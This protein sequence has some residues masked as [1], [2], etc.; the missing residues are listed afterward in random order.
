MSHP[1]LFAGV[2]PFNR[3]RRQ[4]LPNGIGP[5][6]GT[7]LVVRRGRRVRR[8]LAIHGQRLDHDANDEG[9][10]GQFRRNG[11]R[12]GG[13]CAAGATSP[14]SRRRP[15]SS[16]WME[17]LRRRQKAPRRLPRCMCYGRAK[18][19]FYWLQAGNLPQSV[20]ADPTSWRAPS[21]APSTPMRLAGKGSRRVIPSA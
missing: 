7:H 6:P 9:V 17:P 19:R 11:C 12:A 13:V 4:L 14:I 18:S 2:I 3:N 16:R 20:T 10:E 8:T 5:M 1:D 15:G 21:T